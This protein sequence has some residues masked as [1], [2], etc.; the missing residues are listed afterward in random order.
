MVRE[1]GGKDQN[2]YISVVRLAD[3]TSSG[4]GCVMFVDVNFISVQN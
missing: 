1:L 2:D 3:A 4:C